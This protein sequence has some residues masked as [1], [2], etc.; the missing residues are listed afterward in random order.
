MY[1]VLIIEHIVH[2]ILPIP[3]YL[4]TTNVILL[5]MTSENIKITRSYTMR[6]EVIRMLD[7]IREERGISSSW[8]VNEAVIEYV[9]KKYDVE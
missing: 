6:R 1:R 8:I 4:Y 3:I 5:Y 9:N 2:Q 7:K